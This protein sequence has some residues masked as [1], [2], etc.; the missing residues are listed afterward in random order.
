MLKSFFVPKLLSITKIHTFFK[1]DFVKGYLFKGESHDFYEVVCVISGSV[2][3]TAGKDVFTL[4]KGE[5]TYHPPGEFH[6]IWDEG[7][8]SPTVIIFSF[9]AS[10]F[11]AVNGKIFMLTDEQISYINEIYN[12]IKESLSPDNEILPG[13][14]IGIATAIKKTEVFLLSTM[15]QDDYYATDTRQGSLM[16]SK[17]LSV[18][19]REL[20]SALNVSKMA[21]LCQ[22]SV[23]T[24]EKTV[25][26]YLGYGAM[27]HYNGLR[28]QKAQELLMS[29]KSVKEV[30]ISLGFSNQNYFSA[31]FKKQYGYPP[32]SVGKS[33][34]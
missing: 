5:V 1:K 18:M 34:D 4:S 32:S 33:I 7:E 15:C 20:S 27:A 3:I 17:I 19:E 23:P 11:P 8:S 29:G 22:T 6:A 12:T 24:L 16:F 31:R 2:G 28:L 25:Y 14:E 9:D 21:K 26:K 30:S 10:C 13:K